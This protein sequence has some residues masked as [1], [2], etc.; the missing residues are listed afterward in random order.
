MILLP[1]I[2]AAFLALNMGGSGM[3][4]AF[5]APY[6]AG[7]IGRK[8][9]A[10]LFSICV[11]LGAYIAGGRVVDTISKGIVS[12]DL[13]STRVAFVILLSTGLSLLIAN[14]MHVAVSTSSVTVFSLIS[15][16]LY[17][18]QLYVVMLVRIFAF[19]LLLPV[20]AYLLTYGLG[21]FILPLEK[22]AWIK[23]H[24]GYLKC[25]VVATGCYVAFSIGSNNV[26]N[27]VGPLVGAELVSQEAGFLLIAPFFGIGGLVFRNILNTVGKEITPI[28]LLGATINGMIVGT[29]L[30]LSSAFGIPEPM[31]MLDATVIMGIG[32]V[33][34]G[35]R[36]I[37][38]HQVVRKII[39]LWVASPLIALAVTYVLLI[40]IGE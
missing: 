18:Q 24:G 11:L 19:W 17:Y 28:G 6:G 39:T 22:K 37:A 12:Q 36:F 27:A 3:S 35:H 38:T 21:K 40:I 26:A 20:A 34:N 2:V 16:G 23:T 14:L 1:L 4:P 10:I 15:V 30:L 33:N 32:G 8:T 13:I 25:F 31:V 7:V 29:L 9:A 5:S